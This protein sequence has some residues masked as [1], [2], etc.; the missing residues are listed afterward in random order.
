MRRSRTSRWKQEHRQVAQFLAQAKVDFLRTTHGGARDAD[1]LV[2]RSG[3]RLQTLLPQSYTATPPARPRSAR[4]SR[5]LIWRMHCRTLDKETID[6][7]ILH[8]GRDGKRG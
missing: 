5:I 1:P 6:H 3:Q 8:L 7:G 2:H 4:I